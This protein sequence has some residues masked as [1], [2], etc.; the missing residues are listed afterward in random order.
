MVAIVVLI[1]I[2][3]VG[4]TIQKS[5]TIELP[6]SWYDGGFWPFVHVAIE[7]GYFAEEGLNVKIVENKGSAI[8]SQLIGSGQYPIGIVSGDVAMI[9]KSKGVPLKVVGVIDK[10]SHAGVTCHKDANVKSAKDLEGKKVGVTITSNTYQQYLAFTERE[11]VDRSKIE[12]IPIGG[13][14]QEFF[15]GDV[16]CHALSPYVT[17]SLAELKDVEVDTIVYYDEGLNVYSHTIVA[18][19]EAVKDNPEL[20]KKVVSALLKGIKF[21]KENPEEAFQLMLNHNPELSNPE[22]EKLLFEKRIEYDHKLDSKINPADGLQS[23]EAW[24]ETKKILSEA[25][26]LKDDFELSDF[27]TNEFVVK[28]G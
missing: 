26:L 27:Y 5:N 25:G 3:V 13:P 15:A 12:E 9:A 8:T 17:Q 1:A 23:E 19:G 11:D 14:G 10:V 16:D 7:K 6:V 20:V 22:Y 2:F 24:S 21:E 18:N 4:C 28:N